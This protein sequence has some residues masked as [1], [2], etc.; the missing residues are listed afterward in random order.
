MGFLESTSVA[1]NSHI[2]RCISRVDE[3]DLELLEM[4]A[5]G[6]R[7]KKIASCLVISH[8]TVSNHMT[9]IFSQLQVADRA[10]AIVK[11]CRAGLGEKRG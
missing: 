4:I 1:G 3:R 8:K 7:N 6:A 11:A 2:W 10:E 5:Q 9:N